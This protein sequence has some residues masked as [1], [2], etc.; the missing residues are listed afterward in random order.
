MVRWRWV[1]TVLVLSM[2]IGAAR[3]IWQAV[4]EAPIRS[5][6][7]AGALQH[8]DRNVLEQAI[9]AL[10]RDGFFGV[11]VTAVRQAIER[12]AWVKEASVRRI[13]P[14][15][16]H[17][18]V[19]EREATAYW[20]SHQL[21]ESDGTL[22]SP[23]GGGPS[24]LVKLD[25]PPGTADEVLARYRVLQRLLRPLG[26]AV[27]RL[28]LNPRGVWRAELDNGTSLVFEEGLAVK[29]L[30]QFAQVASAAFGEGLEAVARVDLRYANGFAVRWK[31]QPKQVSG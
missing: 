30:R 22:F 5:V 19:I 10:L 8:T 27:A 29:R 31:A 24:D 21:L 18:A 15:S 7:I 16:L 9:S 4:R 20:G 6:R 17:V 1:I 11:D 26:R 2:L 12:L 3:P 28:T 13:W 14:D 25:G 23:E